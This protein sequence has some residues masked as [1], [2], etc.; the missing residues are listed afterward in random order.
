[1]KELRFHGRSII[2]GPY[3]LSK[4]E[5]IECKTAIVVAGEQSM[6]ANVTIAKIAVPRHVSH[7][8][9]VDSSL[10]GKHDSN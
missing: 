4:F 7:Q 10:A 3:A 5:S 2:I 1:L 9:V 8:A 6:S